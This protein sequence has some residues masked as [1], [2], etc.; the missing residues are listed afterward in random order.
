MLPSPWLPPLVSYRLIGDWD[1]FLDIVHQRYIDDFVYHVPCF[2][3]IKIKIRRVPV[4][5]SKEKAFWHLV[6]KGPSEEDRVP[7]IGRCEHIAWVRAL[8]EA[9]D[10]P[11]KVVVWKN[12]RQTKRGPVV[13]WLIALPDFSFV[14]ILR[15]DGPKCTLTTGYPV[16]EE[17][18]RRKLKAECEAWQKDASSVP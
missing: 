17:H 8:I 6:Q 2:R 14:V 5:D 11:S 12:R 18:S 1:T 10:D 9:A 13:N 3:G 15:D 4:S 7:E 16:D